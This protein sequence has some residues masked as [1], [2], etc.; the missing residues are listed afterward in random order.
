M[1]RW[2]F[3]A[4]CNALGDEAQYI[5]A[6]DLWQP[7]AQVLMNG[8]HGT[9]RD[10]TAVR[11]GEHIRTWGGITIYR[12]YEPDNREKHFWKHRNAA[13]H[14]RFLH[15][16]QAPNWIW[17][18]IGNEPTFDGEGDVRAMCKM[19]AEMIRGAGDTRLVVYNPSVGGF[20]RSWI[21]AGW[22]DELLIALAENAHKMVDGFPQ[23]ML[24]SHS[25]AYWHG[26]PSVHCAG[27]DPADLIHPERL[28][29]E[30][31]PTREQI[32][33]AD[34]SDNWILFRDWWFIE[35]TRKLQTERHI[36]EGVDIQIAVTE[37]G[38]ENLPN[39]RKQ[40]PDVV[41]KMD[42]L[43]G[44]ETRGAPTIM[45][46]L[47]WAFPG[48]SAVNSLC[49]HLY[50][51]ETRA[52]VLYRLFAWFTW[53][54]HNARPEKWDENYNVA[55]VYEVVLRY[56]AFVKEQ[57][58]VMYPPLPFGSD[59][60][61]KKW[62]NESGDNYRVRPYPN[63]QYAESGWITKDEAFDYIPDVSYE[64]WIQVKSLAGIIGWTDRGILAKA[65]P[66]PIPLPEPD[67]EEPPTTPTAPSDEEL[68]LIELRR[69]IVEV[70]AAHNK[71][72]IALAGL[73][74]LLKKRE[75]NIRE[76]RLKAA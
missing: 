43:C 39:I 11:L 42:E 23:F 15:D 34:T 52:P 66:P 44:R 70:A 40:F 33:D 18:Q 16:H 21:D 54:Y 35:R 36:N 6:L 20:Q 17:W 24:G 48:Q 32:F 12:P 57:A 64:N 10:N 46:Y 14:L 65:L 67:E 31:W 49:E 4:N 51:I 75:D 53:S 41:K 63:M 7:P 13:Q 9:S 62:V 1:T 73:A 50:Y 55:R 3:N 28:R 59:T 68:A 58:S 27:R 37:A 22:F 30:N 26:I 5:K 8:L 38:P 76:E 69:A 29:K 2:T 56:P 19:L 60:R 71:M 74:D 72:A 25:A 47:E 61:F 45:P